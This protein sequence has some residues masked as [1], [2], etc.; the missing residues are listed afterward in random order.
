MSSEQPGHDG[1][2]GE[3]RAGPPRPGVRDVGPEDKG[4]SEQHDA[5]PD[6]LPHQGFH[7]NALDETTG[8]IEKVDILYNYRLLMR[9]TRY[10]VDRVRYW[11]TDAVGGG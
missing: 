4:A 1:E 11:L 7:F 9:S 8:Q 2:R 3:G 6:S 5:L 10:H